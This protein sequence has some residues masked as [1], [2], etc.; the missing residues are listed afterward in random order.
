MI[1][2]VA[3][4]IHPLTSFANSRVVFASFSEA[5]A[6]IGFS[7]KPFGMQAIV[8]CK[9]VGSTNIVN[10]FMYCEIKQHLWVLATKKQLTIVWLLEMYILINNIN[11]NLNGD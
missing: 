4:L 10:Y 8:P 3:R 5:F 2:Q 1:K 6:R 11:N 7:W 9:N